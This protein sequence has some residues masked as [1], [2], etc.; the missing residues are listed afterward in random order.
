MKLWVMFTMASF[1][2]G[3]LMWRKK[4]SMRAWLLAGLC[5]FVCVGYFFLHQI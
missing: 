5:A 2:I 4:A 1:V 3:V